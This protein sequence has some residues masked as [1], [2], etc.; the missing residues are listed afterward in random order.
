MKASTL[1]LPLHM[2]FNSYMP[3]LIDLYDCVSNS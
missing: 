2:L 3:W 1:S